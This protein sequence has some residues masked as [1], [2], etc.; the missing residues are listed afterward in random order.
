MRILLVI[1]TACACSFS[2]GPIN[3]VRA[4]GNS[5]KLSVGAGKHDRSNTPISVLIDAPA[6]AKSVTLVD[7]AGNKIPG[8]L[9]A[10]GLLGG[11][12]KGKTQLHFI[13]PS[14][15]RGKSVALSTE[16]SADPAPKGF[17]WTEVPG[18]HAEL[19]Y[20]GRGVLRYMCLT[21]TD[22]TRE[23]AFKVY[24]HRNDRRA[25]GRAEQRFRRTP[26]GYPQVKPVRKM[27]R[28]GRRITRG[29]SR[30]SRRENG[31]VP[32]ANPEVVS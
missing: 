7:A 13:L 3:S 14:L 2:F 25:G 6:S 24:H 5:L 29:L 31:T 21:L 10:P 28:S 8:Q 9:T 22:A 4:A 27:A 1:T 19:S 17:A 32:L 26:G 23:D 12:A 15:K 11:A 18:K 16:F 20:A 30:F